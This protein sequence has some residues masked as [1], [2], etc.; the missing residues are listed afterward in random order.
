MT[1]ERR[2]KVGGTKKMRIKTAAAE[3]MIDQTRE[4][5]DRTDFG[6]LYWKKVKI[7]LQSNDE[8]Q[9]ICP[10][11]DD[12]VTSFYANV[13]TGLFYCSGCGAFGSVFQFVEKLYKVSFEEAVK[14]VANFPGFRL[15][16]KSKMVIEVDK[17]DY[18]R[19]REGKTLIMNLLGEEAGDIIF[20]PLRP[21]DLEYLASIIRERKSKLDTERFYEGWMSKKFQDAYEVWLK[22]KDKEYEEDKSL[23]SFTLHDEE[24]K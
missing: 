12:K 22:E 15:R 2:N 5:L 21:C 9:G 23:F 10:F 18:T 8:L 16:E 17:L 1:E 11:H 20:V 7:I 4:L 13:K 24:K 19:L 3:E 14:I 6:M